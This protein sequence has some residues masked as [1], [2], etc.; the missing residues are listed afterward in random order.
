MRRARATPAHE[1]VVSPAH[2]MVLYTEPKMLDAYP[3]DP[4]NGGL[5][6]MWKGTPYA[7][8]M[9]PVAPSQVAKMGAGK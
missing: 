7:H 6:V 2:V 1:W 9:V 5:W 3:T 4:K 8:L